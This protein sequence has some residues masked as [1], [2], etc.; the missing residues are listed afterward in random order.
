MPM[1]RRSAVAA[2]AGQETSVHARSTDELHDVWREGM[3]ASRL[4]A[5]AMFRVEPRALS[6]TSF[7]SRQNTNACCQR[8]ATSNPLVL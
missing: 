1:R 2:S 5:R 7:A 4:L 3:R 6:A 8:R